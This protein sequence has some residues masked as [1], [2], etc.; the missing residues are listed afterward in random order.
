MVLHLWE[1]LQTTSSEYS[2]SNDPSMRGWCLVKSIESFVQIVHPSDMIGIQHWTSLI[3]FSTSSY[4]LE[5]GKN[6]V[7]ETTLLDIPRS[8]EA[9]AG[10]T[11][12]VVG[13]LKV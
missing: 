2:S 8:N 13:P 1:C 3:N 9:M 11:P 6:K 10:N 7:T 4:T 5:M 12:N